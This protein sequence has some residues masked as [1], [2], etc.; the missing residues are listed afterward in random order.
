MS[1]KKELLWRLWVSD[2]TRIEKAPNP[3]PLIQI[4]I[5]DETIIS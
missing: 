5:G 2:S 1:H 4:P 3:I